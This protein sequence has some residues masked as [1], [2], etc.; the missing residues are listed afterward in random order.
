LAGIDPVRLAILA[1]VLPR[2]IIANQSYRGQRERRLKPREIFKH[3]I[4]PPA[5]ARGFTENI[6]Q[7]ILG[8]INVNNLGAIKDP[9]SACQDSVARRVD[10]GLADVNPTSADVNQLRGFDIE[11]IDKELGELHRKSL[12]K[13]MSTS[14][15]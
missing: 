14:I 12:A 4:W 11:M 5:I 1:D 8:W 2:S 7:R 15:I 6:R 3:I 10:H 13:A 9:V